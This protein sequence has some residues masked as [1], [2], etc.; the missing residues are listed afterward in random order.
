[1]RRAITDIFYDLDASKG[2]R[3]GKIM[4]P[5]KK[6]KVHRHR[7]K[8]GFPDDFATSVC[9]ACKREHHLSCMSVCACRCHKKCRCGKKRREIC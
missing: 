1:M 2:P 5:T 3:V 4:K 6:K 7:Y 8:A 9:E